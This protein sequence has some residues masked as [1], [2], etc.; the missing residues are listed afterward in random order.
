MRYLLQLEDRFKRNYKKLARHEQDQ[1]D[2]KLRILANDPWHPS[3]RTKKI[4][5][6]SEFEVSV[7]M[8]VRMAIS[9]DGDTIIVMLDIGHHD[10]L[11]RR[12][13]R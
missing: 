1:V 2:A 10:A 11:L 6:T 5:G 13:T 8:D 7:N 12:R 4:K 9:F 3:L